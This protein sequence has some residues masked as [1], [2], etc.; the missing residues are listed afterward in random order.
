MF[1][2]KVEKVV[3]MNGFRIRA[4]ASMAGLLLW[5]AAGA[6]LAKVCFYERPHY[7]GAQFCAD[8]SDRAFTPLFWNDRISS[9]K[10]FDGDA[11]RLH[12][13]P[14]HQGR[15]LLIAA[16][17]PDLRSRGFDDLTSSF[18]VTEAGAD[19]DAVVNL[20]TGGKMQ[21]VDYLKV[22]GAAVTPP[23]IGQKVRSSGHL[24]P[25]GPDF[26]WGTAASGFQSEGHAPDSNW[27]RYV[28]RNPRYD[29]YGNSIDFYS[30]YEAD[31]QRAADLGV[32]VFRI[33][34]EWARIEP[35]PGVIDPAG[36]AFYDAV[37]DR[38]VSLGMRPM[39]TIDH[40]VYPGW[41]LDKGGWNSPEMLGHWLSH[42]RRVIDRYASRDPLWV[43]INEPTFYLNN[44]IRNGTVRQGDWRPMMR[45]LVAA[46]RA[47]YD[48]IHARQPGAMV[49]SNMAY[50]SGANAPLDEVFMARIA[51]KLD[52]IGIDYYY[53]LSPAD[54]SSLSALSYGTLA[55][56]RLQP[57]GIYYA[58]R[59][60]AERFPGR[61]LYIVE[62]GMPTD[63]GVR[64]DGQKRGDALL[65][66]VYWL[67]RAKADGMNLIGYNYWSLTD[68][69][70]WGSYSPR[71]GLYSVDVLND[72]TLT[73][74]PTDAVEVYKRVIREHGVKPG[75][76]PGVA[77][78]FC[79]L[80]DPPCSCLRP[81]VV[82]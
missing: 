15:Q 3:K 78:Q 13:H 20:V 67:Q 72:P 2:A 5:G 1:S 28:N 73:R 66:T 39:L 44:E 53:G 65:D 63:N 31:L 52:Y 82:P 19:A 6:T 47:A 38:I 41:M 74:V 17:A 49:S 29:R 24:A 46:H 37:I 7:Q 69:Y 25:L 33:G 8:R 22:V 59:H 30:R 55:D 40:W 11:V 51:D 71:F 26:L 79:S 68:N 64:K 34:I 45:G 57:E 36:L 54:L 21:P 62:N 4:W 23:P 75:F 35:R 9:V 77:P 81:V 32:K 50:I 16:D 56:I 60:Y 10:V 76:K 80:V 12:E 70:E 43:T 42:A 14:L 61:P 48:H 27:L 58:L 18:K